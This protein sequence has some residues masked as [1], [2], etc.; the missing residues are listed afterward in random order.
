MALQQYR[1]RRFAGIN[2]GLCENWLESGESADAC[3]METADGGLTVAKGYV[4]QSEVAFPAPDEIKRLFVWNRAAGK[5]FLVAT[6]DKIYVLDETNAL[7]R[8]LYTFPGGSFEADRYDFQVLKIGSTEYL[9]IANGLSQMAKWDGGTGDAVAFG[10]AEGLSDIHVNFV[11]LYFNRLFSAGDPDH[12]SRLYWS[13]AP[14]GA[15][16]IESWSGVEEGENVSGGYVDVGIDSD[17]ITG[18]FALSNQLVLLKRDSVFRL[19]G[20]RPSNFR[21]LPVNAVMRQPV[22]T[23]CI[24]YGDLL[25]FL[26]AGGL[27]Y[28]DGQTVR[29]Q[30][31]SDKV[32]TF[33]E[34]ADLTRTKSAVCRDRLYFAT[35]EACAA[36]VSD[37]LLTY[38]LARGSYMLRRG[39]L[40]RDLFSCDGTL[41]LMDGGG[42]LCRFEEGGSYGGVRIDAWWRSPYTDMDT[43]IAQKRLMEMYL[44]G[45]GGLMLVT[46]EAGGKTVYYE[47]L[48]PGDGVMEIPLPV[49]GRVFR[50]GFR[51][52]NGSRFRVD[53]GM[54][55][56]MDMQRRVL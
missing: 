30:A 5:L 49:E 3:N 1:I 25:Y 4:H 40:T 43:K 10:T 19:L 36:N 48:P 23:G 33:L 6:R 44:R 20:D 32:R 39:F 56:L 18:L 55:A 37:V 14:G 27:Y 22:H 42:Y 16:S 50:F 9:L 53:S 41:Y 38:D 7:W 35:R 45:Q 8:L 46:A 24:R 34:T 31:D 26:N 11:E 52:V 21:I 28:Y 47:H 12:P 13:Q 17:P 15:R 29:R 54:E 51:N 2:Q